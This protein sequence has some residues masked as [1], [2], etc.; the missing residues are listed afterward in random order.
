MKK[1]RMIACVCVGSIITV[2]I[3]HF[4]CGC[5][6]TTCS[7]QKTLPCPTP[8]PAP[9]TRE[10]MIEEGIIEED[11]NLAIPQ[12]L[13]VSPS[14]VVPDPVPEKKPPPEPARPV[15]PE[16]TTY[17]IKKGDTLWSISRRFNISVGKLQEA[18]GI[19]DAGKISVGQKLVIPLPGGGS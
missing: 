17:E 8:L 13:T 1:I 10:A 14:R 15:S 16:K 7:D 18:N 6:S 11:S 4:I 3:W 19:A 5:Q 12:R 2:L 9:E